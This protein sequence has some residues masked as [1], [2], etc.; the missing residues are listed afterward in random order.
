MKKNKVTK[1]TNIAEMVSKH[2]KAAEVMLDYGLYC[3]GCALSPFDTIESG[4]KIHGMDKGE[5]EE[6]IK[7]IN[8][9]VEYGE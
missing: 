3:V 4:A 8:E 6:M 7:R 1:D 5:V 9:V 2:P